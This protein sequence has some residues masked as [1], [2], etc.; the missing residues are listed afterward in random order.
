[1]QE[2]EMKA[3]QRDEAR[4]IHRVRLE[5]WIG[6]PQRNHIRVLLCTLPDVL[7]QGHGIERVGMDKLM[8]PAAVRTAY[9]KFIAKF[10]PDKVS[11]RGDAEQTY[12]ATAV[13]AAITEQWKIFAK[14]NGMK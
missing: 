2:E 5:K 7:W 10:H 6:H 14:E 4:E 3:K 9:R 11:A 12:I 1:M 8:E 13:F